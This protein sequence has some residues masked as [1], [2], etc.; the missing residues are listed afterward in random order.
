MHV[1]NLSRVRNTQQESGERFASGSW[2]GWIVG[3]V[4]AETH[5]AARGRWLRQRELLAADFP[6]ELRGMATTN[7]SQVIRY[8]VA[9]LLFDRR[10]KAGA[11]QSRGAVTDADLRQA[12]QVFRKWHARKSQV[13][14]NVHVGVQLE[15]MRIDPVITQPKFIDQR[16]SKDVSL[17]DRH[18]AERVVFSSIGERATVQ[19]ILKRRRRETRLGFIAERSEKAVFVP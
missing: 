3:E 2:R 4:A 19:F 1:S 18:T 9:V 16:R 8:Y 10:Q 15:S 7:P 17:A 13:G 12:S 14:R 6:S 11:S 5:G